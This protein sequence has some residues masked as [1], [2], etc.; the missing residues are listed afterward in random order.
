MY[1]AR[2]AAQLEAALFLWLVLQSVRD[3]PSKDVVL[4]AISKSPVFWHFRDNLQGN[5]QVLQ[6]W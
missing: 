5:W 2:G 6:L 3:Q 1:E 4:E